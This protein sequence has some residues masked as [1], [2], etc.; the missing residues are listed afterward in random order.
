MIEPG[1]RVFACGTTGTGKSRLLAYFFATFP[2]Q[3]LLIDHND[4]YELGRLAHAEGC[5]NVRGDPAA[6]DWSKRTLRYVP[7][8]LDQ[9][10]YEEL[11]K[12]VWGQALAGAKLFVWMDECLGPTTE[13]R[14][15]LHVRLALGQG[16]KKGLTHGAASLR[17]VGIEKM[18]VNQ[19]EHFFAFITADADDQARIAQR[20]VITV[21][22]LQAAFAELAAKY[23]PAGAEELPHGC[24]YHRLGRPQV[25]AFPPLDKARLELTAQHVVMP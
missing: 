11:Y 22:E 23:P 9:D 19:S 25:T 14:S 17:P 12:I 7:G 24:L 10:E 6:L 13:S 8:R 3:R 1:H 20:F 21:A 18:I 15:P 4:D 5:S 2:G 16:R